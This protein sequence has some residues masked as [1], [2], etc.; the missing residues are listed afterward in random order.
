[1]EY[2]YRINTGIWN[3]AQYGILNITDFFKGY[4]TVNE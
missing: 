3:I 1:M 2:E 4:L